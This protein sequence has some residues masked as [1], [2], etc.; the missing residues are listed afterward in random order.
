MLNVYRASAGSGKTYRLAQ[1]Y[2]QLLFSNNFN[3]KMYRHILAVTFTNKAT[4]EMKSRILEQLY[5]LAKGD[6]S[7]YRKGLMEK[8][9]LSEEKVNEKAKR[10]LVSLL[11]DYSA[12]SVSTIDRFFQQII[13]SFARENGINGGY[14]LELDNQSILQQATDNLFIDLSAN[15]NSQLFDWIS[16]YATERITDGQNWNPQKN[17]LELGKELFKES[18]QSKAD[19]IVEKL[20]NHDFLKTYK[21]DLYKIIKQFENE[22]NEVARKAL[23]IMATHGLEHSDFSYSTTKKFDEV[24]NKNYKS[25]SARFENMADSVENCYT[26][27]QKVDVISRIAQAY[28]SGLGDSFNEIVRLLGNGMKNYNSA[29]IILKNLNTLGVI[30]YLDMEI[31]KLTDDQNA[32]LISDANMLVNRIIDGSDTPFIYE[33]TGVY[34]ENYMIDEFQ[35]TS[36]LQWRNFKPLIDNSLAVGNFNLVVGDVKQSIYR[37]RNSDWKL[38]DREIFSDFRSEQINAISLDSNWRSDKNIVNFNNNFF[39]YASKVLQFKL[40]ENLPAEN[41]AKFE[42]FKDGIIHAYENLEQKISPKAGD[43]FLSITFLEPEN[44]EEKWET[45]SL[46]R[47][48]KLL[49]NIQ[50][51]GFEPYDV[52]ILV[53][54]K[55]ET[56]LITQKLLEY[57]NSE[58]AQKDKYCY[59]VLGNEGLLISK[60]GGVNFIIS[61]LQLFIK[62]EDAISRVKVNYEYLKGKQKLTENEALNVCF[63]LSIDSEKISQFFTDD[64]NK[65]LTQVSNLSLFEMTQ[66]IIHIF[67]IYE[68]NN[69]NVFLQAFQDEVFRFSTGRK[70][71]IYS[72]I[73]WWNETGVEKFIPVPDHQNAFRIMTIHKSK[74]LDFKVVIIPFCDWEL[75]FKAGNFKNYLWCVPSTSPFSNLSVLPVEYNKQLE[76][77]IFEFEYFDEKM[78]RYI[79]NLNLA[80]VAFTRAKNQ[81]I[82]FTEKVKAPDKLS[83]VNSIASLLTTCFNPEITVETEKPALLTENYIVEDSNFRL[84]KPT[85]PEKKIKNIV[86]KPVDFLLLNVNE[87]IQLKLAKNSLNEKELPINTNIKNFGVVMHDLLSRIN[88]KSDQ[89]NAIKQIIREGIISENDKTLIE[90]EM[91]KFWSLPEVENWFAENASYLNETTILTPDGTL[92][93][94]DKVILKDKTATVVD[95]KFGEIEKNYYNRQVKKYMELLSE[96]GYNTKGYLYYFSLGKSIEVI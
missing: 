12:F 22:I 63:K 13:R 61:L 95:Y 49:E 37:W 79:D 81:M 15:K 85:F 33:K 74:G 27:K 58:F 75:D 56:K 18:F 89:E 14:N 45:E 96:M 94:P 51:Q 53:R 43:G 77:S 68:W 20:Q 78:H 91:T 62:P 17:I 55:K 5:R 35:D 65:Q 40:N 80:Y 21:S 76:N 11:Y 1:D 59:D 84:G 46:N 57:K 82:C 31:K 60:S 8:Y 88:K 52:A 30:S 24:L 4:E 16:R 69:E 7:D 32:M 26:K 36:T 9:H 54:E 2:I 67:G 10:I 83:S 90:E 42:I 72:F 66:K 3:E 25:V 34:T 92:Y 70:T 28:N 44:D 39:G 48:P 50:D 64:E 38:L 93:R 41:N 19:E 73:E 71:D 6:K 86:A 23:E 29:N 47:L 87:S